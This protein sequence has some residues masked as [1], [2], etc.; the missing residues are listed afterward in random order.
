VSNYYGTECRAD[1][2]REAHARW[3]ALPWLASARISGVAAVILLAGGG[4]IAGGASLLAR[5]PAPTPRPQQTA[6]VRQPTWV[7]PQVTRSAGQPLVLPLAFS[8]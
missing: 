7:G 1:A 2:A 8:F 5:S 4:L 6:F 3:T